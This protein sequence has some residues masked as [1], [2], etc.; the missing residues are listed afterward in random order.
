MVFWDE[1]AR[2]LAPSTAGCTAST[3]AASTTSAT[4]PARVGRGGLG[5]WTAA[6]S[7]PWFQ[8]TRRG[9]WCA[10]PTA[11]WARPTP[12]SRHSGPW[13]RWP[14]PLRPRG[15]PSAAARSAG[16]SKPKGCA[17]ARCA[18]GAPAATPTSPQEGGGHRPLPHATG[19]GDGGVRR[20]ARP[21]HPAHLPALAGLVD[22]WPPQQAT[23]GIQPWSP[24]D[25]GGRRAAGRRSPSGHPHRLLPQLDRLPAV[26]WAGGAGQPDRRAG[27]DL[28]QPLQPCQLLDSGLAGRA[29]AHP[30]G[31]H[32][33]RRL[34]A[35]SAAAMVAELPPR[36]PCRPE[37]RLP[38]EIT[39]ATRVATCQPNARARPWVWGRPPSSPRYRRRVLTYRIQG[40]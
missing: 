37:L 3:R 22:R 33:G 8:A 2:R 26:P 21:G 31:V 19:R 39:L 15:S 5:S 28:R 35:A 25:P 16:S 18:P 27:G 10:N 30:P 1:S 23:L 7:S 32:P 34:L 9:G 24:Q 13:T 6:G 11:A 14:R 12:S 36:R 17:G 20:P 40:T 4:S 29:P 38:G